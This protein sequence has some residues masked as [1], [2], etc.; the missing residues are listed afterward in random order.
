MLEQEA[1]GSLL[2][3]RDSVADIAWEFLFFIHGKR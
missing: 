1:M 2:L 3:C